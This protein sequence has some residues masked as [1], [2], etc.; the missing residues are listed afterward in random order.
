MSTINY[1]RQQAEMIYLSLLHTLRSE[2]IPFPDKHEQL[3]NELDQR[4]DVVETLDLLDNL[5][6]FIVSENG[7]YFEDDE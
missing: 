2:G 1:K 4:Y 3:S 7:F 6:E 5:Y